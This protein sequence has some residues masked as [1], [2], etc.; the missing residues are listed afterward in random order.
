[1]GVA[2]FAFEWCEFEFAAEVPGCLVE[3]QLP[4][5]G[6]EVDLVASGLAAEAAIDVATKVNRER[7]VTLCCGRMFGE[8]AR[9]AAL[10]TTDRQ[11]LILDLRQDV[12]N[13]YLR[14]QCGVVDAERLESPGA[15][16]A[17]RPA[18]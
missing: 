5:L 13:R 9:A 6:P 10:I 17:L 14:A 7:S 18:G 3:G 12:A 15:S 16:C 4:Q 8:R 11:W 2:C 1:M